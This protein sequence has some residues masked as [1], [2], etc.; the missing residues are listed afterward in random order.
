M[1]LYFPPVFLLPDAFNFTVNKA[2]LCPS[3][4]ERREQLRE[5]KRSGFADSGL[6]P[7]RARKHARQRQKIWG[8]HKASLLPRLENHFL[9]SVEKGRTGSNDY[10][11]W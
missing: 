11:C 9:N 2:F 6:S 7:S 5:R 3:L 1:S 4:R 8:N 10:R